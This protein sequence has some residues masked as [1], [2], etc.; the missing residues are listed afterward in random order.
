MGSTV[1]RNARRC[2]GN[3]AERNV[4]TLQADERSL[5]WLYR[6]LIRVRRAEPPLVSGDY[7]PLCSR[8]DIV[9]YKRSLAAT[10]FW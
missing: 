8:N 1:I 6:R 10:R 7:V 9:M 3:V 2:A 5:L 4:A